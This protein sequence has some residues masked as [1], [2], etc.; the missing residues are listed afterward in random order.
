LSVHASP[1]RPTARD[2]DAI[3]AGVDDRGYG[4]VTFAGV[5]LL[6]IGSVNFIEGLAAIGN[7][8]FFVHNTNYVAGSLNTWGWV[9]LCIGA[10]Q[11]VVGLGVFIQNQIARWVGVAA[12]AAN[13][14]VQLMLMPAYPFWSLALFGANVVALYGL[15]A[16]GKRGAAV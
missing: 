1:Q 8:R 6:I 16:H 2:Y 10:I 12:L 15:V 3:G 11:F 13:A 4:W 14:V 9:V 7:A 5:L